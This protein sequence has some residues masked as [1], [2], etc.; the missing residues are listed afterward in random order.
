MATEK[1]VFRS[2]DEKVAAIEAI[3]MTCPKGKDPD[4]FMAEMDAQMQAIYDAQVD[5]A[6]AETPAAETPAAADPIPPSREVTDQDLAQNRIKALEEERASERAEFERKLAEANAAMEALKK[7]P[8]AAPA[9]PAANSKSQAMAAMREQIATLSS[10]LEKVEDMYAD[11]AHIKK[12]RDLNVLN[13]KFNMMLSEHIES[14][15]EERA[16]RERDALE[17]AKKESE[18]TLN[19]RKEEERMQKEITLIESF[20]KGKK[21]FKTDKTFNQMSEDYTNFGRELAAIWFG[22]RPKTDEKGNQQVEYAVNKFLEG[23]PVLME[24]AKAKGIA[25]PAGLRQYLQLTEI[26]LLMKGFQLNRATA[27]WEPL[28]NSAGQRVSFPNHDAAYDYLRKISGQ[29]KKDIAEAQGKSAQSLI[30]AT[31]R[32]AS[33][34]E[35]DSSAHGGG[36]D[37]SI[38]DATNLFSAMD[39]VEV[40]NL[41]RTNRKHPKVI[42]YDQLARQLQQP[43]L[44]EMF[45]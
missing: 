36:A 29:T 45:G 1:L 44:E 39:E 30:D 31:G 3:P 40:A 11:E 13:T 23:T 4:E 8:A 9:S 37:I 15:R 18:R 22:E 42:Q 21:E 14:D 24:K 43:T 32:R 35:L 25:E 33:A 19:A 27:T 28:L 2:E 7:A 17:A 34:V 26:D 16:T 6:A 20:A 12:L 10:D 41:Y 5:P 38:E